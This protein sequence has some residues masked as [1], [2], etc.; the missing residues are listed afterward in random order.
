[1]DV[2]VAAFILYPSSFIPSACPWQDSN[3]H[4]HGS[5]P[6]LSAW[7]EY[8]GVGPGRIERPSPGYRPGPLPLRYEPVIVHDGSGGRIRTADPTGMSRVP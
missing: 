6:C 8:R 1:M 3:L 7:L 2:V 5:R 4:F